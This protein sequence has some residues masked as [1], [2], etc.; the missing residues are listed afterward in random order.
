MPWRLL[1]RGLIYHVNTVNLMQIGQ[2]CQ[3]Q[4]TK[5]SKTRTVC[6][7]IGLYHTIPQNE[8]E[9]DFSSLGSNVHCNDVIMGAMASQIISLASVYSTVYSGTD[10]RNYQSFA[11]LAFVRGIHRGPV[12][13]PHKGPV[14]GKM[15][16][17]DDV[18]M[19]W[20]IVIVCRMG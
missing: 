17:F 16:P 14:M 1:T 11:S 13:S 15:F 19:I 7:I 4:N 10:Q 6:I 20:L 9:W 3:Y 18:V 2:I 8:I 5:T 12:N